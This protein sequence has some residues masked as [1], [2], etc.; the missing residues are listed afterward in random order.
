MNYKNAEI[1]FLSLDIKTTIPLFIQQISFY[2]ENHLYIIM[3][4]FPSLD[5]GSSISECQFLRIYFCLTMIGDSDFFQSYF[6][7][8]LNNLIDG[9]HSIGIIQTM[10][11]IIFMN[12]IQYFHRLKYLR[13]NTFTLIPSHV[14]GLQYRNSYHLCLQDICCKPPHILCLQHDISIRDRLPFEPVS[15][16]RQYFTTLE[17]EQP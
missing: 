2:A 9:I 16:Y 1:T 11:M 3:D 13:V 10:Y 7:C 8:I 14:F 15:T 5:G 4:V 12:G 17:V 6:P